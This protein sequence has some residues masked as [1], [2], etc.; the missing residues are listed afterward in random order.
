MKFVKFSGY[1]IPA[2]KRTY[3]KLVSLGLPTSQVKEETRAAL[4]LVIRKRNLQATMV[5]Y[6]KVRQRMFTRIKEA[7]S[8]QGVKVES[9]G[10]TLSINARP[11]SLST[12]Q[13]EQVETQLLRFADR[14]GLNPDVT[15]STSKQG[16]VR[17][18]ANVTPS[19]RRTPIIE[20]SKSVESME[21]QV[22]NLGTH[23]LQTLLKDNFFY[24][25]LD[26]KTGD[27]FKNV[28]YGK[29]LQSEVT[30]QAELM[31]TLLT[32]TAKK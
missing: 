11:N 24:W 29:C 10:N 2:N 16:R 5:N 20:V 13:I 1:Y 25:W 32:T 30:G 23:R 3:K 21:K 31:K 26:I 27:T 22:L 19:A 14:W 28:T 18:Y 9:R 7:L 8:K 15:V 17:I 12:R 4:S 6:S